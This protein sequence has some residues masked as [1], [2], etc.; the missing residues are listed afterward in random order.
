MEE[1]QHAFI[2]R[3]RKMGVKWGFVKLQFLRG[4]G[5]SVWLSL[6]SWSCAR[7]VA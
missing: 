5:A 1:A 4:D 7:N 2:L 3:N 6:V